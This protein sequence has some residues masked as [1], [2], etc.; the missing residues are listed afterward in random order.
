MNIVKR[1]G[2]HDPT[3]VAFITKGRSIDYGELT[4]L[5]AK[6]ASR[7]QHLA[8]HAVVAIDMVDG[9]NSIIVRLALAQLGCAPV[10][11]I[12]KMGIFEVQTRWRLSGASHLIC[13]YENADNPLP[14]TVILDLEKEVDG[15]EIFTKYA[16]G[17][18]FPLFVCWSG[19]TH[20]TPDALIHSHSS[21]IAMADRSPVWAGDWTDG[22][23]YCMAPMHTAFFSMYLGIHVYLGGTMVIEEGAFSPMTA[24]STIID[25]NVTHFGTTPALYS[26]LLRRNSLSKEQVPAICLVAGDA[27]P[28]QLA[29]AWE[30]KYDVTLR[31]C[32]ASSQ[33][34]PITFRTSRDEPE[35][36]V[37]RLLAGVEMKLLDDQ[38][39]E[40]PPGEPGEA[41]FRS[42]QNA[43]SDRTP[44][45]QSSLR[46]DWITAHDILRQTADG[47][48]YFMG[49]SKDTFKVNGF[50]VN[51]KKI[52]DRVR[53]IPGIQDAAAVAHEDENGL[54]RVKVYVVT[55]E[56]AVDKER[57]ELDI[58]EMVSDLDSHE[59]VRHVEFIEEIPRH[60]MSQK[61]Q[62][63]RL[64][65]TE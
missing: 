62:K 58:R 16:T 4:Y 7:L 59:R 53:D 25:N 22:R 38:G 19:G 46:G 65:A 40:V 54:K 2:E 64:T 15:Y 27:V 29:R 35:D 36:S 10:P 8:K 11:L 55:T 37:G 6:T 18:D 30:S 13:D 9:I 43:S 63:F 14:H 44:S 47:I 60:P 61:V 17:G 39:N 21:I 31:T 26:M 3:R 41:W 5:V 32:L 23:V 42:P 1:M 51:P 50:F 52:E 33:T 45:G 28:A 20:G 24:A 12:M 57:V 56:A 34:G 49:R 48:V